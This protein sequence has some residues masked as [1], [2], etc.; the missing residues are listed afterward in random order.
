MTPAMFRKLALALPDAEERQHHG[1][2]DFRV[3]GKIFATLGYPDAKWA[4]VSLTPDQQRDFVRRDPSAFTSVKG[5]WGRR[6]ATSVR[7]ASAKADVLREAL[8][9]A[10]ENRAAKKLAAEYF[11]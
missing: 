3:S 11:G 10:W 7:L 9:A 6:G 1:H 2:P 8:E 5:V 4:M